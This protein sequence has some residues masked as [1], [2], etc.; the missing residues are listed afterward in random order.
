MTSI[1]FALSRLP[2][3]SLDH[4]KPLYVDFRILPNSPTAH[5]VLNERLMLLRFSPLLVMTVGAH[6][7]PPL[8]VFRSVPPSPTIQ[9]TNVF[10]IMTW[11]RFAE[12]PEVISVQF[13]P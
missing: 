6:D 4:E 3:S 1:Q 8:I 5:N 11:L 9:P 12:T 7:C 10:C 2:T 13:C